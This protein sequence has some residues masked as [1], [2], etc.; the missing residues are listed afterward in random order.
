MLL[1]CLNLQQFSMALIINFKFILPV[2]KPRDHMGG[3]ASLCSFA[4]VKLVFLWLLEE[5]ELSLRNFS[6]LFPQPKTVSP[7]TP[8]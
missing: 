3:L 1:F 5:A 7:L 4:L 6:L 2:Y 8:E